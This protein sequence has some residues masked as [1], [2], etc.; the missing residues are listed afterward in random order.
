MRHWTIL[1]VLLAGCGQLP[2]EPEITAAIP[3]AGPVLDGPA[4][5]P[6]FTPGIPNSCGAVGNH[7][8]DRPTFSTE[9]TVASGRVS[10]T[11]EYIEIDSRGP[12]GSSKFTLKGVCYFVKSRGNGPGTWR[13]RSGRGSSGGSTSETTHYGG[14]AVMTSWYTR[15][16]ALS[17]SDVPHS[18]RGVIVR[19]QAV[20]DQ[21]A[22]YVGG[23]SYTWP[24]TTGQTTSR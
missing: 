6:I 2:M 18:E 20:V 8:A 1:L 4:M 14:D 22:S 17:V 5:A 10:F 23:S 15:R 13:Y 12:G 21:A 3:P 7:R 9:P 16:V 11:A 24:I 19:I